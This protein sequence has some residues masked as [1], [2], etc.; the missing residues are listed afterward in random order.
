MSGNLDETILRY[1]EIFIKENPETYS[2]EKFSTIIFN[3][4]HELLSVTLGDILDVTTTDFSENIY[5]NI[6]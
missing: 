3:S 5:E 2:K 1:I 6:N 4:V